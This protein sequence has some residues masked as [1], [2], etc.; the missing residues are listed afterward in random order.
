M[1]NKDISEQEKNSGINE[2]KGEEEGA[3]DTSDEHEMLKVTISYVE[4]LKEMTKS[5]FI[6]HLLK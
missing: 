6:L 2:E 5:K 4:H 1:I 3:V